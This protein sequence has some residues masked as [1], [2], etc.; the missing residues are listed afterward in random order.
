MLAGWL[1]ADLFL[2]LLIAGLSS[3]PGRAQAPVP[4]P[5]AS[6][7][8]T[9][10]ASPSPPPTRP[11]GLDP[12]YLTLTVALSPQAFRAG[13][14]NRLVDLVNQELSA[15]NPEGRRVGFVLVFAS[16][17]AAHAGRAVQTATEAVTLLRRDSRGFE[18][19]A[20]LG[21]WG[22]AGNVFELKVFLMS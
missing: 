15:Q 11:P 7:P 1:F 9:P 21:Y 10:T 5:S 8:P 2:V 14:R 17:D 12:A 3:M 4:C 18:T 6:P 22:G 16:D 13:G 19:A 20:G